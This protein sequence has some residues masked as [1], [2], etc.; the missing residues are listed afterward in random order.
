[1]G[2]SE[3]G[4]ASCCTELPSQITPSY[5]CCLQQDNCADTDDAWRLA[6]AMSMVSKRRV[7]SEEYGSKPQA[8]KSTEHVE[9]G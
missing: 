9:H 5:A 8:A 3:E 4:A 7:E 2:I 1:M 6:S